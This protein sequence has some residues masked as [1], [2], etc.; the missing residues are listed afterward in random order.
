MHLDDFVLFTP[1]SSMSS[2]IS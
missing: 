2:S 1:H